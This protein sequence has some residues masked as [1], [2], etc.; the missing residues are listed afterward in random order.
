[1]FL[2]LLLLF[3]LLSDDSEFRSKLVEQTSESSY[4]RRL[5]FVYRAKQKKEPGGAFV[6]SLSL[7]LSLSYSRLA[8]SLALILCGRARERVNTKSLNF[9]FEK[10]AQEFRV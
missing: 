8:F 7:S 9:F 6:Q 3:L 10:I 1:M 5:D 4:G 2:L